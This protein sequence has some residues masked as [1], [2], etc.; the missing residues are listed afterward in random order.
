GVDVDD[1]EPVPGRDADVGVGGGGPPGADLRQVGG[2][3][4]EAAGAGAGLLVAGLEA[5]DGDAVG[6]V[7]FGRAP[8]GAGARAP[9][10]GWSV[11][12]VDL[13]EERVDPALIAFVQNGVPAGEQLFV[14]GLGCHRVPSCG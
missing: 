5:E 10:L 2:G 4:L 13:G 8:R 12:G 11:G 7:P 6:G 1:V 9:G 3:V 14:A